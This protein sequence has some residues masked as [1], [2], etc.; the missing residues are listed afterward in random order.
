MESQVC[1]YL[2]AFCAACLLTTIIGGLSKY[3]IQWDH[4]LVVF[5]MINIVYLAHLAHV[6]LPFPFQNCYFGVSTYHILF[7][8]LLMDLYPSTSWYFK[9]CC[10]EHETA[11]S[12]RILVFFQFLW[13][14]I[15]KHSCWII[16]RI[17]S[18]LVTVLKEL[19]LQE[20]G[21]PATEESPVTGGENVSLAK[22]PVCWKMG[23]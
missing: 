12:L 6:R 2:K 20:I 8:R 14:C 16:W 9:W 22:I 4:L 5:F 10:Y 18:L 1:V 13:V 11:K 23:G 21:C 3:L 19:R 17:N 7:T 15:Q